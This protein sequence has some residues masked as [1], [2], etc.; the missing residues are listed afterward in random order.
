MKNGTSTSRRGS[1]GCP[2]I[3]LVLF[4]TLGLLTMAPPPLH[5]ADGSVGSI[6]D[7]NLD[8]LVFITV[9]GGRENGVVDT[10][11]GTGFI[12]HPGGYVLTCNHVIPAEKPEYTNLTSSPLF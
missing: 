7:A 1:F 8:S 11:T 6:R 10:F 12:V 9:K 2:W 3:A 5:A 4:L